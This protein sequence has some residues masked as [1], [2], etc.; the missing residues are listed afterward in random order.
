MINIFCL[1]WKGDFRN[2]DY[3]ENDVKNLYN[4][5]TK[6]I[7]YPFNFYCLT[8]DMNANIKGEKIELI[9]NWPGWWSKIELFRP[10][11]PSGIILYLDLDTTIINDLTPVLEYSGDFILF[12]SRMSSNKATVNKYHASTML[13][14]SRQFSWIYDKFK[15]NSTYYMNNYRSEQ[16]LYGEWLPNQPTFPKEWLAKRDDNKINGNAIFL[17]GRKKEGGFRDE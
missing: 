12:D 5:V 8:N 3:N 14:N 7:K 13:F 1:L 17:T 4:S 16:D 10:D 6:N 11:L 15:N 9:N 2:R